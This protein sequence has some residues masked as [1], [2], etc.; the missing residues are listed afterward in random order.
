[1][2]DHPMLANLDLPDPVVPV[3]PWQLEHRI[4]P[5]HRDL[6]ATGRLRLLDQTVPA[7]PT[8]SIRT[9]A[10]HRAPGFL[11]LALGIHI[12][13]TRR[14]ISPTT[15]ALAPV[16][17]TQLAHLEAAGPIGFVRDTA[18]TWLDGSRDLTAIA[19]TPGR[20]DPTRR[21]LRPRH[22][23]GR[24]LPGHRPEPGHRIRHLARRPR[25]M[26]P[27]LRGPVHPTL[28]ALAA[29]GIGLEAHLQ[30]SLIA[31]DG[32]H[33]VRPLIRDLGGARIHTPTLATGLDLPPTSPVDADD[34][35][36][37]RT[38]IGYTL[39]QNHLAAL[40]G[41]LE[42]DCDLDAAAFWTDLADLIASSTCPR[43]TATP[44][45]PNKCPPRPY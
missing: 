44:T 4:L 21:R 38:K 18:G 1:M 35:E 9:L 24:D 45:W 36:A 28:L 40:V 11:K 29:A 8:A 30:N 22:R 32:P 39:F 25:P 31:L 7:W 42:R 3:H 27:H 15:A 5:G 37:V 13:S 23:P 14:D 41:A 12:T 19:R 6:F 20:G 10:G 26:D 2:R 17:H 43:P 34:L 16:L 33:P